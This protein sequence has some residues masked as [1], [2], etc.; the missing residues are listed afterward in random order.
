MPEQPAASEQPDNSVIT[1]DFCLQC[2][3]S[4]SQ[5]T[6]DELLKRIRIQW[7]NSYPV[8]DPLGRPICVLVARGTDASYTGAVGVVAR[9]LEF[10]AI[11]SIGE[12]EYIR[13]LGFHVPP[14]PIQEISPTIEE[15]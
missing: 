1:R 15:D 3:E 9:E 14:A 5:A 2:R 11:C 7:R 4:L 10:E 6:R 12:L 13:E 8:Q